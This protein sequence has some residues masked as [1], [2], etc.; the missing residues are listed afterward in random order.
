MV[1]NRTG[2]RYSG[3]EMMLAGIFDRVSLLLYAQTKDAK[4]GRNR[5]KSLLEE[6]MRDK[7]NDIAA[8]ESAGGFEAARRRILQKE[9]RV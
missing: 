3:I 7:S 2:A 8:F 6:M 5:P 9:D 4:T 1:R